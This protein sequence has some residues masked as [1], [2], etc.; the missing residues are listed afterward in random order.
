MRV[1]KVYRV[2]D[3][4]EVCQVVEEVKRVRPSWLVTIDEEEATIQIAPL[5]KE[6]YFVI[7]FEEA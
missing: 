2:P 4:E 3:L 6:R 5:K 7:R 1:K